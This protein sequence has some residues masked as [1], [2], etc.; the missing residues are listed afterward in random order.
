MIGFEEMVLPHG[1]N[2]DAVIKRSAAEIAKIGA[3][4]APFATVRIAGM[5]FV[6]SNPDVRAAWDLRRQAAA[7]PPERE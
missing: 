7:N 5:R 1:T 3:A 4:N 6:E 2:V